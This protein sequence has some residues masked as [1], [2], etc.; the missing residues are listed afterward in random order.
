M[1]TSVELFEP[2]RANALRYEIFNGTVALCT[3]TR[4]L[5]LVAVKTPAVYAVSTATN[6]ARHSEC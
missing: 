5:L 2:G 3:T 4:H 1:R 6:T